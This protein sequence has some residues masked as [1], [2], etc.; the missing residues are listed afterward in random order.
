[1]P[2][3]R[4]INYRLLLSQFSITATLL[5]SPLLYSYNNI[6]G[7]SSALK[8]VFCDSGTLFQNSSVT[9]TF[10]R[11]FS[12]NMAW[13]CSANSNEGLVNNLKTAKIITSKRVE[14]AMKATDRKNYVSY[15]PYRDSPQQLGYGATISAPHMHAHA[16]QNLEPFLQPSMKVLDIGCGSGYLTTCLAEMVGPEGKV[17]GIEHIKELVNMSKK[18]IQKD[19]PDL[20]ESQRIILIHGDG[21]EGYPEEAPYDCIHVGAAADETPDALINQLKAPGRLFIPVGGRDQYIYQIDKDENGNV[22]QKK[23]MGVVYVP[24]TDADKQWSR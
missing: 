8:P 15:S 3:L 1:M 19:R 20:L 10:L 22:T 24:L 2:F 4:N 12:L 21:R 14:E 18:N 7:L 9:N 23:V 13:Y 11:P 6:S 5:S 16:L 17:V